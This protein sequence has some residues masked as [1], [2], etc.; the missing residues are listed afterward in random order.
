M[1]PIAAIPGINEI[2]TL[3]P[4]IREFGTTTVLLFIVVIFMLSAAWAGMFYFGK[5]L[6]DIKERLIVHCDGVKTSDEETVKKAEAIIADLSSFR[7]SEKDLLQ[8]L[9]SALAEHSGVCKSGQDK[10]RELGTDIDAIGVA[11][12]RI[13]DVLIYAKR[14]VNDD[15]SNGKTPPAAGD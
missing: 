9:Q 1:S 3:T 11:V 5:L 13:K 12:N 2:A 6:V 4:A 15:D 8:N 7:N 10:M 14:R